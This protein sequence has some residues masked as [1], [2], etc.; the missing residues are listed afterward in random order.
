MYINQLETFIHVAKYKSFSQAAR[1]L[2]L[3][4]PTISAHIKSLENELGV[5]LF[6]RSTKDI[7]LSEAGTIFY[8]CAI[9]MIA[10]RDSAT[11]QLQKYSERAN[12]TLKVAA[13]TVPSQY[14]LPS[15]LSKVA[16]VYPTAYC[17]VQQ[18]DS[19]QVIENILNYESYIGIGGINNGNPKCNFVPFYHDDLVV[20][21]PNT[22]YYQAFKG[23]FPPRLLLKERFVNRESGSGTQKTIDD[24]FSKHNIKLSSLNI[25][26]KMQTT[27]EVKK[28][29]AAGLGISIISKIA[30]KDYSEFGYILTYE[31]PVH[32]PIRDLYIITHKDY[33]LPPIA[34]YLQKQLIKKY[35]N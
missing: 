24:F 23:R 15:I 5:Q 14:I 10:T 6:I 8:P 21:T 13:S 33:I 35:T 25:I 18:L 22:P 12:L 11:S 2:F 3:S 20:I 17:Q 9:Q 16:T 34:E 32:A 30:A 1:I 27:E 19:E 4:Q 29:V 28:A 7:E 26:A 31:L